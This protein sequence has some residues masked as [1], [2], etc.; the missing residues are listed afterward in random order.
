MAVDAGLPVVPV[1]VAGSR[2]VMTKGRLMVRPGRRAG[3]DPRSDSHRRRRRAGRSSSSRA[4]ARG[5]APASTS[6]ATEP[7]QRLTRRCDNRGL[8]TRESSR[9]PHMHVT[10]IIAA[11]GAGHR[12]GAGVPEAAARRRRPV[13]SAAQR[14]GVR[15]ATRDVDDVIVALPPELGG[16]AADCRPATGWGFSVGG[17]GARRQDSVANAFEAIDAQH[18]RGAGSRCRAAVRDR[19]LISGPSTRPPS[20]ARRSSAQPVQRHGEARPARAAGAWRWSRPSARVDLPGA[21]AAG[22]PRRRPARTPSRWASPASRRPTRPRS[23]STPAMSCT[24]SRPRRR[25]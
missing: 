14:R 13:D 10:A 5:R 24:S 1:S 19:R 22:V 7:R 3:D 9:L 15:A 11:G 6:P 2:H 23:P 21:D 17:G 12:L 25:T 16:R 18:R 8:P 4:R 20:T